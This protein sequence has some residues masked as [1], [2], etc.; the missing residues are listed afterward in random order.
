MPPS[1]AMPAPRERGH[2]GL[3][4]PDIATEVPLAIAISSLLAKKL[5]GVWIVV[6]AAPA[7]TR[8]RLLAMLTVS[9]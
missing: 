9:V 2:R 7:P 3:S 1:S 4:K 5:A 6:T 8:V